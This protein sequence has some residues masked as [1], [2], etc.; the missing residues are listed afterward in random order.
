MNA[1]PGYRPFEKSAQ[2]AHQ[3]QAAA[4]PV[5]RPFVRGKSRTIAPRLP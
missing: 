1:P 3:A 2:P 4:P 5:Y